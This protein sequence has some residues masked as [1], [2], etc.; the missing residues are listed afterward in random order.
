MEPF[1][2]TFTPDNWN[3]ETGCKPDADNA[4]TV[5]VIDVSVENKRAVIVDS[6]GNI[7]ICRLDQLSNAQGVWNQTRK[8][9]MAV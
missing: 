9:R 8:E 2:A 4:K 1:R 5:V 6:Y 7:D 3:M